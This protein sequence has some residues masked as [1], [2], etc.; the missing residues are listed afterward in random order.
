MNKKNG[1][2]LIELLA[3]IIIFSVIAFITIPVIMNKNLGNIL[4]WIS[5][6][7]YV[8][9]GGTNYG[10]YGNN[11]LGPLTALEVLEERT[12]NWT[13]IKSY[14]YELIDDKTD[15]YGVQVRYQPIKRTNVRARMLT[16]TEANSLGCT[17]SNKSCPTWL[18]ENTSDLSTEE[19]PYGYWLS[20]AA[21]TYGY[22]VY[23]IRYAGDI[24]CIRVYNNLGVRPV[25]KVPKTNN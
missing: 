12:K 2:T 25:I 19:A 24:N 1:F 10:T 14:D 20:T 5:K 7:D 18:Y 16:Y 11:E 4:A 17:S 21:S 23:R 8:T 9:S 13:N 15:Y 3:V 22:N 6:E